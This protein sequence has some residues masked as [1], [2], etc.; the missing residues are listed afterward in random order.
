MQPNYKEI[1]KLGNSVQT[2]LMCGWWTVPSY[3]LRSRY[4][5]TFIRWPHAHRF[6]KEKESGLTGVKAIVAGLKTYEIQI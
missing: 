6:K 2:H 1:R 5:T 4:Q 3:E